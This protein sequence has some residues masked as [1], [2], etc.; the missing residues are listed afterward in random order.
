MLGQLLLPVEP[1]ACPPAVGEHVVLLIDAQDHVLL[2]HAG[3]Q[4]TTRHK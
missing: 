2:L 4:V 3:E 1:V